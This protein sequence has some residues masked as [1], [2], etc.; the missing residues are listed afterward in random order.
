MRIGEPS[1]GA[2]K[3]TVS[4]V[5]NDASA[6]NPV[7]GV[8]QRI[9]AEYTEM[10]GLSL[11][12]DQVVRL[13]GIERSAC[14]SLLAALVDI[15]FL[16]LKPDGKYALQTDETGGLRKRNGLRTPPRSFGRAG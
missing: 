2:S 8:S 6:P 12:L 10:P 4:P 7:D 15:R 14:E 11:T 9:R 3:A 13:C 5:P 16:A 1:Y